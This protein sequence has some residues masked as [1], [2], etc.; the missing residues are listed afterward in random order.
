MGKALA[1]LAAAVGAGALAWVLVR[2][3]GPGPRAGR[4][5]G[6]A[7]GVLAVVWLALRL[8]APL[9]VTGASLLSRSFTEPVA[10]AA[11]AE[12]REA[13]QVFLPG[14]AGESPVQRV[15]RFVER[16]ERL[17]ADVAGTVRR[18]VS[19]TVRQM[20]AWIFDAAVF[21]LA[22]FALLV[23]LARAGVGHALAPPRAPAP[24]PRAGE[25]GREGRVE[26]LSLPSERP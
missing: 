1:T 16:V 26:G 17:G 24:L 5:L 10:Q 8:G 12:L 21:P 19:A 3:R 7:A 2:S 23:A 18:F 15:R 20:V 22:L 6:A 25:G 4:A 13:E 11:H 9:A 14:E